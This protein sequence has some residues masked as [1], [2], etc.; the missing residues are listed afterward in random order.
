MNYEP[1]AGSNVTDC[2]IHIC[3][4]A[5]EKNE[6]VTAKFNDFEFVATP[7][8]TIDELENLWYSD[9]GT[10]KEEFQRKT[11][12][13]P[14]IKEWLRR[15]DAGESVWSVEMG[16]LGPSYEQ[17]IQITAAEMIRILIA[18][19][20]DLTER[21]SYGKEFDALVSKKVF[22]VPQVKNLGLSGAQFGSATCIAD[23]L[24]RRTPKVALMDKQVKDRK[25]LVQKSFPQG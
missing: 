16:G 2:I 24:Y 23:Q 13:Y 10:T 25:I 8:T 20:F 22:E 21:E 1:R 14:D 6:T 7:K 17:A 11:E 18:E 19:N 12:S 9:L 3:N 15:W 4:L 5:K